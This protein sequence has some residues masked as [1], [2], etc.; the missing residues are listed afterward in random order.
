MYYSVTSS[1]IREIK[2]GNAPTTF[3][4]S[5]SYRSEHPADVVKKSRDHRTLNKCSASAP[6]SDASADASAPDKLPPAPR[7]YRLNKSK[8]RKKMTAFFHLQATREFCA[9]YTITF[10]CGISDDEAYRMFNIWQTR[11]RRDYNLHSFIWVAERQK[12]GT[13]HFHMLTNTKMPIRAVN[14]YMRQSLLTGTSSNVIQR[15]AISRYNGVDV[16]NVWY[17][18]RR[19]SSQSTQ[20]RTRDDA[21]RYLGRYITKYVSKNNTTFNRL[22]WHESHDIAALFTA[23]NFDPDEVTLLLSYF[24][25]TK[26]GWKCFSG[27]YVSVFVHPSVFDLTP[28]IELSAVNETVYNAIHAT[29]QSN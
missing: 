18:K 22:A 7:T 13:I 2:V 25:S 20:R 19:K 3:S 14:E 24:N 27:D 6:L 1:C 5:S 23:Q 17:P 26:S 4:G 10:P 11:C 8:I 28:F 29:M 12:N 16:D 21:A 9:F 15:D